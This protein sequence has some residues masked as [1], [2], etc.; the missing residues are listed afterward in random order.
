MLLQERS[1]PGSQNGLVKEIYLFAQMKFI[2]ICCL[3]P[4]L[5]HTPLALL[6][7][8]VA[9]RSITLMAPSK[10]FNLPGFGCSYAIIS[11]GKLRSRFKKAMAGIVPDPP[12][13]GFAL[14]ESAYRTGEPWRMEL[15]DYLRG[16][17]DFAL[18]ELTRD[19]RA[20]AL[21][22]SSHLSFV[23]G[24]PQTSD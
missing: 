12:A 22:P 20:C 7:A 16:N 5:R 14:A 9:D 8:E 4:G 6:G 21:L 13:M 10:T 3:E 2:V 23:D 17:R 11:N 24:C 15:I 19:Q 18:D 1:L